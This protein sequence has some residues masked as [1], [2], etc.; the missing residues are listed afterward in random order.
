MKAILNQCIVCVN[1]I[2]EKFYRPRIT[3]QIALF[4]I[5][6]ALIGEAITGYSNHKK[7]LI[8]IVFWDQ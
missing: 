3:K 1:N 7:A 5:K 6:K 4:C 8:G 2:I